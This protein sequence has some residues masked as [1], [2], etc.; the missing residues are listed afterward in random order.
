MLLP[1]TS[2]RENVGS[3]PEWD[4]PDRMRKSLR[5]SGVGV[6]EMAD[7]LGVAR[8]TVSTWVNGHIAPSKQTLRLWAM[9]T[10]VPLI[11]L[12]TGTPAT[13]ATTDEYLPHAQ[14]RR[15]SVASLIAA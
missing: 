11:W 15:L 12:E 9:R 10:G 13:K 6:Q 7:Y 4:L 8:N 1:M 14:V 2:A 3:I 5:A